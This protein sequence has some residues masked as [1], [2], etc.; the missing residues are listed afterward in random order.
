VLES[1]VKKETGVGNWC[2][3]GNWCGKWCK[4]IGN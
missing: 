1:G 4:D 3:E 2:K